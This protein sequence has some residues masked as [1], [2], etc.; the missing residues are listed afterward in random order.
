VLKHPRRLWSPRK[1]D[2]ATEVQ[3]AQATKDGT[4]VL[5]V[6]NSHYQYLKGPAQVVN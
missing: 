3:P 4:G 2:H 6:S 1:I 5:L